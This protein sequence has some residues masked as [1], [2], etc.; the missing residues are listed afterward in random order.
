MY[1]VA[2]RS[3]GFRPRGR[4]L[5]A[6]R[7][8]GILPNSIRMSRRVKI[9]SVAKVRSLRTYERDLHDARFRRSSFGRR[10][11]LSRRLREWTI[12]SAGCWERARG[13]QLV[14]FCSSRC[15][16]TRCVRNIERIYF[17]S[18]AQS[19]QFRSLFRSAC[20]CVTLSHRARS[21]SD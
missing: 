9:L 4:S 16:R 7:T 12:R 3:I 1:R 18:R 8:R 13:L 20:H 11:L 6:S 10:S 17:L 14:R 2:P 21:H 19:A 15:W 5:R